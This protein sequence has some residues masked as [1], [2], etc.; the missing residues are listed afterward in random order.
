MT[1]AFRNSE[2]VE[3]ARDLVCGGASA[4]DGGLLWMMDFTEDVCV[5]F[6]AEGEG[7][8]GGLGNLCDEVVAIPMASGVDS[9]NVGSA[10]AVFLYEVARQR[11]FSHGETRIKHGF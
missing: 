5:V 9:L 8:G 4:Y 3:G 2:G 10:S 11:V 1:S 6:G 7:I